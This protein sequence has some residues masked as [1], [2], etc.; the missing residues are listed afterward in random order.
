LSH[1][2]LHLHTTFSD[3]TLTPVELVA[4]SKEQ[5]FAAIAITDHDTTAGL[6]EALAA[7]EKY[8]LEV[9]PGIELSTLEGEREIHLLGYYPDLKNVALQQILDKIITARENR[10][11]NMVE[12]LIS[13]GYEL[14]I[15]RVKEIAGS[16][17]IGRPHIA[18]ALLEQGYICDI[19]EAFSKEFI[20]RGGRAYVERFK[21]SP[22]K[23]IELLLQADAV[24]VLAHPGHLSSG[25]P[26][27]EEEI[28]PLISKG[29]RG[30]ETYYSKYSP[31]QEEYYKRIA[32]KHNLLITGGSD[33]HGQVG[34]DNCLGSIKLPYHYVEALK[35]ASN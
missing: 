33:C 5:G 24:P 6:A 9:I 28:I 2:D 10:A 35:H 11:F 20:G 21:L 26:L 19:K 25:P 29:L 16:E 7:G 17:F 34:A 18:R 12:K 13:L 1:A 15:E 31:E 14:S 30:I 32:E 4:L 27:L 23:G 8:Q 3:G 22:G